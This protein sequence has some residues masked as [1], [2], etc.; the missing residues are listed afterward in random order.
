[1]VIVVLV[2]LALLELEVVL[3]RRR[4]LLATIDGPPAKGFLL[5]G[6]EPALLPLNCP[7]LILSV[8]PCIPAST[9]NCAASRL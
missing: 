4:E 7:S 8:C 1:M 5:E 2:V 9:W 6:R 3:E